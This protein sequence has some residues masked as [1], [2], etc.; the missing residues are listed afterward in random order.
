VKIAVYNPSSVVRCF[1]E[2]LEFDA[3]RK[4]R[5][6][7]QAEL[8]WYSGQ[9]GKAVTDAI[10]YFIGNQHTYGGSHNHYLAATAAHITHMLRDM[11][12]DLSEGFVN[13][14]HEWL[15][16]HGFGRE[17]GDVGPSILDDPDFRD[18]VQSQ[19]ALARL[20]FREGKSYLD[21]LDVLRCKIAAYWY[22]AR[23]ECVLKAIENDGYVLRPHYHQRRKLSAKLKMAWLAVTLTFWHFVRRGRRRSWDAVAHSGLE[24]TAIEHQG[25]TV[26]ARR[27]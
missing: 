17:A 2:V 16:D 5:L 23:F 8:T 3:G 14:S 21:G 12:E 19:V 9:L 18:W 1:I 24:T 15:E 10:Q 4:D 27:D 26:M 22:C 6:I 13:I 25:N 7:S 20:Y 11:A